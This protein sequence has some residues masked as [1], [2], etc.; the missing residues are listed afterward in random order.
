[1]VY[2]QNYITNTQIPVDAELY[3]F[4]YTIEAITR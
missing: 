4:T 3:A 1:M 2:V